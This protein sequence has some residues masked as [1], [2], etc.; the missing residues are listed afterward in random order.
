[1]GK[2]TVNDKA[3]I[4]NYVQHKRDCNVV[5]F[6]I[7][8]ADNYML[9]VPIDKLLTLINNKAEELFES[10][11]GLHIRRFKYVGCRKLAFAALIKSARK[12]EYIADWSMNGNY[13][14]WKQAEKA[15]RY[16]EGGILTANLNHHAYD[17]KA[18][19]H[20]IEVKARRGWFDGSVSTDE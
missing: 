17:V 6:C 18:H 10:A 15:V 8:S 5:E 16:T 11:N 7:M 13:V 14:E 19:G 3:T 1:M 20:G 9:Y 4:L 12:V 2:I